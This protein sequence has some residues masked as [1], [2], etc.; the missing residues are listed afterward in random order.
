MG[1]V[2]VFGLDGATFDLILPWC[3][4]GKLPN[5]RQLLNDGVWAPLA[6]VPSMRSPAAWSTFITGK[7][8]GKH[9][10]YEFYEPIPYSYDVRFV[11]GGMRHGKSFWSILS[12]HDKQVG[13]VNVPMTYPVERING[14]ML[15]GLDAPGPYSRGF[16]HPDALLNELEEKHG[17]YVL[18]PGLT[19]C[20]VDGRIDDAVR[21]LKEELAQKEQVSL[22]LMKS[23]PW[24]FFIVVFRSL[25]IAQHC[26]WKYMDTKHPHHDPVEAKKYGLVLLEV[27]QQIDQS[28]GRIRAEL[29]DDTVV[30]VM[31]D[32]GFGRKHAANV[33]LNHW[34]A[35]QG[36]LTF[37]RSRTGTD[38]RSLAT[39]L[40]E[41]VYR[42]V[43]RK[44][45]RRVKERLAR[46]LPGLRN[47]VQT[48][49]VY[50]NID[51]KS[52]KAYSDSLFAA[53]RLNV[54]GRDPQ[55]TVEEGDEYAQIVDQIRGALM[56][57]RDSVSGNKI[58]E[59]VFHRDEIYHG[60]HVKDAPDFLIR[61]KEDEVIHGIAMPEGAPSDATEAR[62]S[63]PGEDPRIISGDHNF[64]GT[65]LAAGP[66]IK[67]AH[68]LARAH[69]GDLAPT[70]LTLF[71][72]PVPADMDGTVLVEAFEDAPDI[73][74]TESG[75]AETSDESAAQQ[76]YSTE[77]QEVIQQ[78]L[79]DLGY[80]E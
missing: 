39:R 31:S 27:Y 17:R 68:K 47:R 76:A 73:Q 51:W 62:A 70:I 48:R 58:V 23:R 53:I 19:G 38:G 75:S 37:C 71:G 63:V 8:P 64:Y 36:L 25:D 77:D 60:P 40:M 46:W 42:Q 56:E 16:C 1:K 15:A 34:L 7:N 41:G 65:F 67:K 33:Q 35:S 74:A 57:C 66:G 80:I 5:F 44:T 29:D 3:D 26:F 49:L 32:H 10:L 28:L 14:F 6:S 9:G 45:P 72:L 30:M 21:L 20:I 61:W 43:V 13:V 79:R 2:F 12:D 54:R 22:D 24:D 18:E 11:H 55:G 52:T 59:Q 78:R 50:S 4:E 69:L